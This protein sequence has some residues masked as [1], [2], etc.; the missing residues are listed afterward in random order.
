[1]KI[2][3]FIEDKSGMELEQLHMSENVE[4][5]GEKDLHLRECKKFVTPRF[6]SI[7]P[8]Y[9]PK[10]EYKSGV[11]IPLYQ[12]AHKASFKW[13]KLVVCTNTWKLMKTLQCNSDSD[14]Y[15]DKNKRSTTNGHIVS[16]SK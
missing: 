4:V 5:F 1:M 8:K 16:S 14:W 2:T 7:W 11:P 9:D 10:R 12:S 13:I 15:D 6:G 3:M